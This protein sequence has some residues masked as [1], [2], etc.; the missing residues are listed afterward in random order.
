MGRERL[1]QRRKPPLVVVN[2]LLMD[3]RSQRRRPRRAIPR[4]Q[5]RLRCGKLTSLC[6]VSSSKK[7]RSRRLLF[8][9]NAFRG[10]GRQ[11]SI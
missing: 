6:T 8:D 11:S 7:L 9:F 3:I 1:E 2:R 5:L 4:A 10:A